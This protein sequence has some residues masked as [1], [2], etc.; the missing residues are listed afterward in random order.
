MSGNKKESYEIIIDNPCNNIRWNVCKTSQ[1]T[2]AVCITTMDSQLNISP[3]SGTL[4][5]KRI[6]N[7]SMFCTRNRN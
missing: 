6:R 4:G 2:Q 5:K 1:L 7:Y 3:Q